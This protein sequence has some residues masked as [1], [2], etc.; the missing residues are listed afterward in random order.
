MSKAT[1]AGAWEAGSR[2]ET[3]TSMVMTNA[4]DTNTVIRP[5]GQGKP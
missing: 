5:A 1:D 2:N 3:T 4:R